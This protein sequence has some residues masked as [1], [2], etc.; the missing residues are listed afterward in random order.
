MNAS[1][2]LPYLVL[3]CNVPIFLNLCSPTPLAVLVAPGL[4]VLWDDLVGLAVLSSVF[5]VD[6]S[7]ASEA[8]VAVLRVY[9]ARI[10]TD[11]VAVHC[12]ASP[13]V[14]FT[15][16]TAVTCCGATVGGVGAGGREARWAARRGARIARREGGRSAV[17]WGMVVK[18]VERRGGVEELLGEVAVVVVVPELVLR[19]HV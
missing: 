14:D 7:P 9:S 8:R 18:V 19:T 16:R 11:N 10:R 5:S 3:T 12:W 13:W 15:L 1:T 2:L 17:G 4:V 6:A